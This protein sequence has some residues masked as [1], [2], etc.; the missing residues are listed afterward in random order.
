[1]RCLCMPRPR[2]TQTRLAAENIPKSYLLR[3]N[4][5][6]VSVKARIVTRVITDILDDIK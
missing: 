2:G 1:M 4:Y 5:Y 6:L 3:Y